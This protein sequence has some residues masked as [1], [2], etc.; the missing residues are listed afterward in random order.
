LD[1]LLFKA[2]ILTESGGPAGAAWTGRVMQIGNPGDPAYTVLKNGGEGSALVMGAQLRID[3]DTRPIATPS[4]N[5]QAGIAY[6]MTKAAVMQLHEVIDSPTP[7]NHVV[8]RGDAFARI[9][10]SEHTTLQ[11][12]AEMNPK[13]NAG[14]LHPGQILSFHRAHMQVA[15]ID[16]HAVTANFLATRY[17]GGGDKNYEAKLTYVLGKLQP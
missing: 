11:E 16:W 12:L 10:N 15:I 4:L 5:I 1:W 17:N 13:T 14:S 3:L 8:K 6:V 2:L 9:A 7:S